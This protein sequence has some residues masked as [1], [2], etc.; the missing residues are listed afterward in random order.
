MKSEAQ[1]QQPPVIR[2]LVA[3]QIDHRWIRSKEYPKHD[4]DGSDFQDPLGHGKQ[5]SV[6]STGLPGSPS[7]LCI[8]RVYDELPF[9]YVQMQV[10]NNTPKAITVQAIRSVDAVGTQSINLG[11][12]EGSIRILSVIQRRNQLIAATLLTLP[13]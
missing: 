7:R 4:I 8:L 12:S 2:S 6:T 5:L 1:M 3:A 11:A 13:R 9:G 10:Q